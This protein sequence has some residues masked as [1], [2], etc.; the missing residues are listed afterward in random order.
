M[1]RFEPCACGD[2]QCPTCGR[3]QGTYGEEPAEVWQPYKSGSEE[4]LN[5]ARKN[6]LQ[7]VSDIIDQYPDPRDA[8]FFVNTIAETFIINTHEDLQVPI[9][10][11]FAMRMLEHS[12]IATASP[13]KES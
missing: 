8:A 4:F 9:A 10:I 6:A 12:K 13:V 1:K 2:T 5:Q 3:L 11:R 7:I